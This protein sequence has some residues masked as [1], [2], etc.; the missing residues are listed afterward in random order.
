MTDHAKYFRAAAFTLSP[1]ALAPLTLSPQLFRFLYMEVYRP[2]RALLF[3]YDCVR[4]LALVGFMVSA[5][6][7][8]NGAGG[9]AFPYL[10]LAAPNA[11]FP[12]MSLFIWR[13]FSSYR[14]YV[15]LYAAGKGVVLA[16]ALGWLF[17][18]LRGTS[19]FSLIHDRKGLLALMG[20]GLSI[21]ADAGSAAGALLLRNAGT[22]SGPGDVQ[23]PGG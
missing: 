13:R 5:M 4:L 7:S 12:L 3:Y 18:S 1:A 20:A 6:P 16:A 22:R 23:R 19:V 14:T 17:F 10:T 8:M 9:M 15:A 2:L 21:L 11:L